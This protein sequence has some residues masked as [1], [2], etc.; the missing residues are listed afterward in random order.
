[1]TASTPTP[2]SVVTTPPLVS[3]LSKCSSLLGVV[4]S[5]QLS[6]M[7]QAGQTALQRV[8]FTLPR[9]FSL[10]SSQRQTPCGWH[11]YRDGRLGWSSPSLSSVRQADHTCVPFISGQD[12]FGNELQSVEVDVGRER[13]HLD[14]SSPM[15]RHRNIKPLLLRDGNTESFHRIRRLL[16]NDKGH[17]DN[18]LPP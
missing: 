1:M 2:R 6:A 3:Q 16:I 13:S 10:T 9:F 15:L 4:Q 8:T 17:F 12:H 14:W 18:E 11:S 5:A 7:S